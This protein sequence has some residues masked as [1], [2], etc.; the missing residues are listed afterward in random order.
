MTKQVKILF[1]SGTLLLTIGLITNFTMNLRLD[2][3]EVKKEWM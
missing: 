3:E 1:I 2:K